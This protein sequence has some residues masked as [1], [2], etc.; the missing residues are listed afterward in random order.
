MFE[1]AKLPFF[2]YITKNKDDLVLM[3]KIQTIENKSGSIL[4]YSIITDENEY[5]LRD[6]KKNERRLKNGVWISLD[7]RVL[8]HE[9]A[10]IKDMAL[11]KNSRIKFSRRSGFYSYTLNSKAKQAIINVFNAFIAMK[12]YEDF[13]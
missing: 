1:L 7:R 9:Y 10:S 4:S 2:L 12:K 13:Q 5:E 8:E 6:G 11:S 3:M